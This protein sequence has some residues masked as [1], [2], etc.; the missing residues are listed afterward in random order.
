MASRYPV[1]LY[2][3]KNCAPCGLAAA[4]LAGRG[5]PFTEKTVVSNEDID[6]CSA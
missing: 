3:G 1:V 2:T 5:I 6:A 4:Y